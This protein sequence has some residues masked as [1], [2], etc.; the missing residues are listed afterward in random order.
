MSEQVK[1]PRGRPKGSRNKVTQ[2]ARDF[3]RRLT[4]DKEYRRKLREDFKRRKNVPP[5]I[6]A[7]VWAYGHGKPVEQIELDA[8]GG[9]G[10]AAG[11]ITLVVNG[12]VYTSG[13]G[14]R[15]DRDE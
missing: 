9:A 13:D 7:M 6:E 3:C 12:K 5:N 15:S 8:P 2:E 1:R 10:A 4:K 11:P 14:G